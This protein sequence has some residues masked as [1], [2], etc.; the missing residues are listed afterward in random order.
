[1]YFISFLINTAGMYLLVDI[2]RVSRYIVPLLILCVTVP[3]N[4]F[5]SKIWVFRGLDSG[6]STGNM[7]ER[8]GE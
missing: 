6:S 5:S 3:F 8:E 4:Y 2:L 7:P 1:V